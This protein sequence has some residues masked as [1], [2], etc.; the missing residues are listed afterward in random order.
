VTLPKVESGAVNSDG[1]GVST[2]TKADV[3][4]HFEDALVAAR[5]ASIEKCSKMSEA[6]EATTA[7]IPAKPE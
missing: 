3:T 1:G 4:V 7:K 6:A 5:A 2:A